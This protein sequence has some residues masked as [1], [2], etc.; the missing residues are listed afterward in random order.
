MPIKSPNTD[1]VFNKWIDKTQAKKLEKKF[2]IKNVPF[3]KSNIAV[4]E[5][6]KGVQKFTAF[7]FQSEK[8]QGKSTVAEEGKKTD[9]KGISKVQFYEFTKEMDSD[10][11]KDKSK[12][13]LYES[14][15]P[16]DCDK[17]KGTGYINCKK[18]KGAKLVTCNQCKGQATVKCKD[19]G[20]TGSKSVDVSV[21][22]DGKEK[23]KNKVKY[24]C[25]TCFGSANLECKTCGG[26]GKIP[27]PEC[28]AN[29]RY[30]C[31][32]CH[33]IGHFYDYSLG[34]VPFKQTGAIVPHLYFRAD[35]A[36]E[37]GYRLSNVLD[38]VEGIQIRDFKK[39]NEPDVTAQLGYTPDANAKKMMQAT[40][41]DFENLLKGDIE[42]AV[43]PIYIFPVQELDI[44]TPQNKKF[45]LFS[46][47]SDANYTVI[48]IGFE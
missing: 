17:C 28:K 18:C 32:K 10:I 20:G 47:G 8:K 46:I 44:V 14:I 26:T 16:V 36:K 1:D 5:S 15:Q 37:I 40:K 27:C 24:N 2:A 31:D 39:L 3:Q 30:R 13:P 7:Y 38:Q 22:K 6:V 19:C 42:K 33:G 12:V 23:T 43:Y 25:P 11:W 45:K 29:A 21:L 48:D 41:K 34:F 9:I 35:V 4:G